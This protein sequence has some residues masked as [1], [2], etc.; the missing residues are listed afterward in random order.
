MIE[1]KLINE[2]VLAIQKGQVTEE[3]YILLQNV[4]KDL[5]EHFE[6]QDD[7]IMLKVSK[8]SQ[9]RLYDLT[10]LS[11]LSRLTNKELNDKLNEVVERG[12]KSVCPVERKDL[13]TMYYK[14]RSEIKR[15]EP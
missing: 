5:S 13:K 9:K 11:K 1:Q 15:R 7:T 4:L 10:E 14:I 6:R 3:N 12:R 8:T 2:V